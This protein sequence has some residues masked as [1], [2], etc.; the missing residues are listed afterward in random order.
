MIAEFLNRDV[1]LRVIEDIKKLPTDVGDRRSQGTVSPEDASLV[2]EELTAAVAR[3]R[4]TP[5][6]PRSY[7][8][9]PAERRRGGREDATPPPIEDRAFISS[10]PVISLLQ[11]ALDAL[12][13]EPK[14][15]R[16][17]KKE[18]ASAGRRRR[19]TAGPGAHPFPR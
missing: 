15:R 17:I 5:T 9:P 3:E 8:L 19:P 1:V 13:Q 10:D 2:L 6:G 4:Q 7:P 18:A 11:S 16:L 12:Y 14:Y